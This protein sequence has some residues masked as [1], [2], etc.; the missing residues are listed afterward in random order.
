MP[1]QSGEGCTAKRETL[2]PLQQSGSFHQ[3]LSA[4][5]ISQK[6]IKFKLQRGDGTKEGSPDPCKKGDSAEGNP[7]QDAQGVGHHKQT[8]FLNTDPFQQ[9]Y[10]VKNVARVRVNGESCMA[11]LDNGMQINTIIPMC[12]KT[13]SPE[14][15]ALSDLVCR[16]VTCVGLGNAFTQP[17]G[18]VVIWLQVDGVQGYVEESNSPGDPRFVRLHGMSSHYFRD[19]DNQLH[20]K[21]DQGEGD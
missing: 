5:E 14:V 8:P 21:H 1:H 9:W 12:I 20:H 18:Y 13:C 17:L 15:G 11:L 16:W 4:G 3:G 6:G 10:G 2:L 19:S 7:G